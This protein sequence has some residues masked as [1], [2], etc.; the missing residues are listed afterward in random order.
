MKKRSEQM[1]LHGRVMETE[2][3]G[4]DEERREN[5]R[6]FRKFLM[7]GVFLLVFFGFINKAAGQ[8][9]DISDQTGYGNNVIATLTNNTL[10]ISGQW[11]MA[12]FYDSSIWSY[13]PPWYNSRSSIHSVIIG[14]GIT[15]IGD[16]AF[17]DC[18][19]LTS[20]TIPTTVRII[21]I[22]SFMNC[23]SLKNITLPACVS[24]IQGGAFYGCSNLAV[25]CKIDGYPTITLN[26]NYFYGNQYP[27]N[28][29]KE[30]RV[31]P[32]E[33]STYPSNGYTKGIFYDEVLATPTYEEQ[34]TSATLLS[35]ES[36]NCMNYRMYKVSLT[37]GVTYSFDPNGTYCFVGRGR[38]LYNSLGTELAADYWV[39]IVPLTYQSTFTGDAYL[40]V[41][42]DG[43]C[44]LF[45]LIYKCYLS[46]PT[47][48]T[49][50]QNSSSVS[51]SWNSVPVATGYTV[52][53]SD[54]YSGTYTAIKA[55][56]SSTSTTDN[57][58]LSGYNY[59][60]VEAHNSITK[61]DLS[62]YAYVYYTGSTTSPSLTVS[63]TTYN[64]PASGGTS[65][66]ITVTSN[67]SWTVSSSASW[68]T[69]SLKNGSNNSIFTMTA[70][71][72]NS[73]SSRSTTVTV[74][75]GEITG[76]VSV[77]QDGSIP[78]G[79]GTTDNGVIINGVKWATRNVDKPGTFATN[80]ESAGMFYQWN[81][82][83]GW[84]SSDPMIN[85]NGGTT[86]DN[87]Q[88]AGTTWTE[89]NDP[90]PDGW[91]VPTLPEIQGLQG[92]GQW[93][94]VNGVN[95]R[96]F[97]DTNSGNNI[98][99]PAV[100]IR[101]SDGELQG[102]NENGYYRTSWWQSDN[103]YAAFLVFDINV[104]GWAYWDDSRDGMCIR[105]VAKDIAFTIITSSNPPEGGSTNGSGNYT[106]GISCSVNATAN[107]GYSFV[108]WTESG[109]VVSTNSSYTFTVSANR[110]LV[111]NFTPASTPSGGGTTDNGV[112]INGVKWA[113]RNVDKPGTFAANPES[114]GMFYQWNRKV[115][116]SSTDPMI[117]SIGGTNWDNS[118]SA[119]IAWT[120]TNDPC[121]G[122]WRVPTGS[123][124]DNLNSL[125]AVWTQVNN[126]NGYRF[127]TGSNAIFLPA[128]GFRDQAYSG[129][130]RDENETGWYWSCSKS[131]DS[132]QCLFAPS[133]RHY[134]AEVN[135]TNGFSVRCVAKD[136]TALTATESPSFSIYP[137]PAHTDLFIKTDLQIKTVEICDIS[138][139]NVETLHA[140][141]LQDGLR[142]ISVS[143]LLQ[144]IYIVKVYTDKG[145]VVS[146]MVKE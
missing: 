4:K 83:V 138:G 65:T 98:F 49:A 52:Y 60:K 45:T 55:G 28:G 102:A 2:T 76:T 23:T 115:G 131:G 57:S 142:K 96:K 11:N 39:G 35:T 86:W 27:F 70:T 112:I 82:R 94:S 12:D 33:F 108:N 47:G 17:E 88:P 137:N 132:P 22:T 53:R 54:S 37:E 120:E 58:P 141:P 127:G 59:Y 30:L 79:G 71:A 129:E 84:S 105:C 68:L 5:R 44:S 14:E 126:V 40:A 72:N 128:A 50:T 144:G 51:I 19:N 73:T 89:T 135:G 85:S 38:G 56:I 103:T 81:K 24:E 61:S 101:N 100:G 36:Y 26:N 92:I 145:V 7:F 9:W 93:T 124:L 122:G 10:T 34:S 95:G 15:N 97:T 111:A 31:L 78:S 63:P 43:G 140:L 114:A 106:S 75:G 62:S 87:S 18:P 107:N 46:V 77:T 25:D 8:T 104:D 91:R 80:P 74:T 119:G 21:G 6:I 1:Q 32:W 90:C 20:V 146:K 67:E 118:Q 123:E 133:D 99:L 113:T 64:F 41:E 116:W 121:P 125:N 42:E 13:R 110:T 66:A 134:S 136:A 117:N 29:I 109:S 69:T 3:I 130:H 48:V 16:G 143:S 139:R